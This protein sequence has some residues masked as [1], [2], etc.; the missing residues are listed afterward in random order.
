MVVCVS[1]FMDDQTCKGGCI[2]CRCDCK[3]L[4]YAELV[5][6]IVSIVLFLVFLGFILRALGHTVRR[7]YIVAVTIPQSDSASDSK[8]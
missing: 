4:L 7:K 2:H 1:S 8:D 5:I 3:T 6:G